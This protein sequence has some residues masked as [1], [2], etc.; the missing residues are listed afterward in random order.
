MYKF[1]NACLI[2]KF[3]ITWNNWSVVNVCSEFIQSLS[4]E[5]NSVSV[6]LQLSLSNGLFSIW[7]NLLGISPSDKPCSDLVNI[8]YSVLKLLGSILGSHFPKSSNASYGNLGP[9][10]E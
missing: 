7:C 4:L 10:F 8:K 3:E 5:L 2:P 6:L 1:G 9:L